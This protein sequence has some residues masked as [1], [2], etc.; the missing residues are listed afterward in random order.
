MLP[1]RPRARQHEIEHR[2]LKADVNRNHIR[3]HAAQILRRAPE[4]PGEIRDLNHEHAVA[5]ERLLHSAIK[6][7][8]V[9][10]REFVRT[11]ADRREIQN[12]DIEVS[13]GDQH[14]ARI[15]CHHAGLGMPHGIF[16]ESKHFGMLIGHG[17][18]ERID[19][20]HE[21]PAELRIL[22]HFSHG[23]A[24]AAAG[25]AD[26]LQSWRA[27]HCRVHQRLVIDVLIFFNE[28]PVAIQE[29]RQPPPAFRQQNALV[30]AANGENGPA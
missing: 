12:Q 24:V 23:K 10:L 9:E 28:L 17:Q 2:E 27:D 21:N 20:I 13:A 15:V 7:R 5:R 22:H 30:W 18:H 1:K 19:L 25:N 14:L 11:V 3:E 8:A 4:I 29:Q 6:R 16:V 26:T